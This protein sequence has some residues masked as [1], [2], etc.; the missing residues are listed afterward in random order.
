MITK[1]QV[2]RLIRS[3]RGSLY[4][5]RGAGPTAMVLGAGRSGTT[6]VGSLLA[7]RYH[8]RSMFEPFHPGYLNLG[9][10]P[11]RPVLEPTSGLPPYHEAVIAVMNGQVRSS[12]TDFGNKVVGRVDRWVIKEIRVCAAAGYL[13]THFPSVP[14]LGLTRNPLDNAAS[15][16]RLEW[17]TTLNAHALR[18]LSAVHP[19]VVS[20]FESPLR[21]SAGTS[22]SGLWTPS[23]FSG[24]STAQERTDLGGR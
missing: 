18:D 10:L 12:W 8:A 16:Q 23:R 5:D 11:V 14:L 19:D 3:G 9:A 1:S 24:A 20:R 13:A 7:R 4:L 15:R 17:P 21:T 22:A 6:W 2:S